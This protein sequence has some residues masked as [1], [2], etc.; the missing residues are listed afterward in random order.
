LYPVGGF[1][2]DLEVVLG[3]QDHPEARSHEGLVVGD[4]DADHGA[5]GRWAAGSAP[6]SWLCSTGSRARSW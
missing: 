1:A 5:A 6:V 2:D 4:E 3:V